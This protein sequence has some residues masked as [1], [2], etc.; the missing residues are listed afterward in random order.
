MEI[1]NSESWTYIE[2]CNQLRNCI[3]HNSG[4]VSHYYDKA[5]ED[6]VRD[7]VSSVLN[8]TLVEEVIV[9][10]EEFCTHF[11]GVINEILYEVY[12]RVHNY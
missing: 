5:K 4:D 11:A 7:S 1:L 2:T 6:K 12:K 8:V 10:S 9:I 3:V